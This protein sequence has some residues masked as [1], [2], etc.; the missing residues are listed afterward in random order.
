M[1][2]RRLAKQLDKIWKGNIEKAQESSIRITGL[3]I[4]GL[5]RKYKSLSNIPQLKRLKTIQLHQGAI[6]K[7]RE[8]KVSSHSS[9]VINCL[10]GKQGVGLWFGTF[11]NTEF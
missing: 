3:V 1:S 8:A 6:R 4:D 5:S 9:P 10:L 7:L 2:G 11:F